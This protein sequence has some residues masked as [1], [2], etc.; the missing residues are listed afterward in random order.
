MKKNTYFNGLKA[1]VK[2]ALRGAAF[3]SIPSGV[4]FVPTPTPFFI[5][6]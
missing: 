5:R 3:L 1:L 4:V 6:R 2:Q